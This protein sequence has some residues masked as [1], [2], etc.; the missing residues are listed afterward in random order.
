MFFRNS[1]QVTLH[2]A[3]EMVNITE[4]I[5]HAGFGK[6]SIVRANN[7][8]VMGLCDIQKPLCEPR[9]IAAVAQDEATTVE[10]DHH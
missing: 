6:E 4:D 7:D 8:R 5:G 9:L 1:E 2:P 3:P 10:M